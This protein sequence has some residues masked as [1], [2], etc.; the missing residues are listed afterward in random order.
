MADPQY[1]YRKTIRPASDCIMNRP[2][3]F[4]ND[5]CIDEPGGS[6]GIRSKRIS[7]AIV[8]YG[9]AFEFYVSTGVYLPETVKR[10]DAD[11]RNYSV[12]AFPEVVTHSKTQQY[13]FSPTPTSETCE[14][15]GG[16]CFTDTG[17]LWGDDIYQTVG[18][19]D[20]DV[21]FRYLAEE[22]ERKFGI[23]VST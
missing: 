20:D 4:G 23:G 1:E 14:F 11:N 8:A 18:I 12:R 16:V 7:W 13:E 22:Y 9:N 2:C 6:H 17:A 21:L 3:V 5:N 19:N 10:L 15:T